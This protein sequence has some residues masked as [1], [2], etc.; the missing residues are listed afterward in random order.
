MVSHLFI[1]FDEFQHFVIIL[2][3]RGGCKVSHNI[4]ITK[5]NF[6][7]EQWNFY[8]FYMPFFLSLFQL[9]RSRQSASSPHITSP[10]IHPQQMPPCQMTCY[11]QA[12]VGK[13][14][15]SFNISA[16]TSPPMDDRYNPG[17]EC[18]PTPVAKSPGYT[19]TFRDNSTGRETASTLYERTPTTVASP[20][21][22]PTF[23]ANIQG[24]DRPSPS[25]LPRYR[26]YWHFIY[27]V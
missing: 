27:S 6:Q 17:Y 8:M 11:N 10:V 20:G 16:K 4:S 19:A 1:H 2:S 26:F 9:T 23:R 21:Y 5:V 15:M 24:R 3:W 13:A 22:T 25:S 18:I 12:M 14:G 7:I